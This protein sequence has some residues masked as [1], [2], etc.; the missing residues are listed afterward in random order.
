MANA[1]KLN[2]HDKEEEKVFYPKKPKF[3]AIP[4]I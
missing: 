3:V 1:P 4:M 2:G